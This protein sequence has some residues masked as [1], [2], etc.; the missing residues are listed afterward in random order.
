MII[1]EQFKN[2]VLPN[3]LKDREEPYSQIKS[4]NK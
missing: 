3:R 2:E 1:K 4:Y